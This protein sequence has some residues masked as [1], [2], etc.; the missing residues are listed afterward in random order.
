M[1]DKELES[2]SIDELHEENIRL[3]NLP[4]YQTPE[5]VS[6]RI[7]INQLAARKT[8]ER[9]AKIK[10]EELAGERPPGQTISV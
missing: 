3:G 5:I 9:N 6:R 10:E 4:E 2:L 7:E 8:E 1:T